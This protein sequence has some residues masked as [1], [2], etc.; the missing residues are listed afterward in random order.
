MPLHPII[1][2]GC[3]A[4]DEE[5]RYSYLFMVDAPNAPISNKGENLHPL[6]HALGRARWY[7]LHHTFIQSRNAMNH[8]IRRRL[9]PFTP[10]ERER[11]RPW[12]DQTWKRQTSQAIKRHSKQPFDCPLSSHG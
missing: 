11:P 12:D 10:R 8:H 6:R 7:Y 5:R 3:T 1:T 4:A 2:P 9:S